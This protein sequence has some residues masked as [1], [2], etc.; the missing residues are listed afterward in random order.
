MGTRTS[1][2][3]SWNPTA[4]GNACHHRPC[5]ANLRYPRT[6]SRGAM[7]RLAHRHTRLAASGHT[8]V[9][10]MSRSHWVTAM[11]HACMAGHTTGMRKGLRHACHH[12]Q[13]MIPKLS[14]TVICRVV[15]SSGVL[16]QKQRCP[17]RECEDTTLPS[18]MEK[19]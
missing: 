13:V 14:A 7:H 10:R 16:G 2:R 8:L 15:R 4:L 11:R 17:E 18:R 9:G 1:H 6:S 19:P 12:D 5:L 3:R